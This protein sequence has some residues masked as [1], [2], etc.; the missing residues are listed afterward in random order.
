MAARLGAT[1]AQ[2]NLATMPM[3]GLLVQAATYAGLLGLRVIP[4]TLGHRARPYIW[5]GETV[6]VNVSRIQAQM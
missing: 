2:Q 3:M 6:T 5:E 1:S 4:V